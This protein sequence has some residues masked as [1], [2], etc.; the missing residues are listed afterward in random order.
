MFAICAKATAFAPTTTPT[1]ITSAT[2]VAVFAIY[3]IVAIYA[4]CT[5]ATFFATIAR[6]AIPAAGIGS[7]VFFK[8]WM[9]GCEVF[10]YSVNPF[11]F[12]F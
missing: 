3:A 1:V 11:I 8:V 5:I 10:A 4:I 2:R 9:L 7:V 6:Y 12:S